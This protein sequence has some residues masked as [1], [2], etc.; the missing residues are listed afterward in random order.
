MW[1]NHTPRA[2][3]HSYTAPQIPFPIKDGLPFP[4]ES[5][6]RDHRHPGIKPHARA[7]DKIYEDLGFKI[8]H[9][10]QSYGFDL[11]PASIIY[12]NI[13]NCHLTDLT[14]YTSRVTQPIPLIPSSPP[15]IARLPSSGAAYAQRQAFNQHAPPPPL[16]V[17][18][19][20]ADRRTSPIAY[21]SVGAFRFRDETGEWR[22]SMFDGLEEDSE[23]EDITGVRE[24]QMA[25]DAELEVDDDRE[26]P[27]RRRRGG[28][29]VGCS[30]A[31]PSSS[32]QTLSTGQRQITSAYLP[33]QT[34]PTV[35]GTA[36]TVAQSAAIAPIP[37]KRKRGRPRKDISSTSPPN[38]PLAAKRKRERPPKRS[39][40]SADSQSPPTPP[41]ILPTAGP[42][43]TNSTQEANQLL[44]ALTPPAVAGGRNPL[45]ETQG[46]VGNV[47]GAFSVNSVKELNEA[48]LRRSG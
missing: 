10:A 32:S 6:K 34:V 2:P 40:P 15:D 18:Q 7:I 47:R 44:R 27:G 43:S 36:P 23:P 16:S 33:Q 30:D 41:M 46:K 31:S 39:P 22:E 5:P 20:A 45:Q 3:P 28:G 25:A 4:A 17:L 29:K 14:V 24:A 35:E 48:L 13:T 38:Q 8:L 19:R 42:I 1:P 11:L 37:L 12:P 21:P 9:Q 26:Q